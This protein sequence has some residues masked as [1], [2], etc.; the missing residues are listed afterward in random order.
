MLTYNLNETRLPLYD[1]LYRAIKADIL[2]GRLAPGEKLPSKRTLAQHLRLSV[3]TVQNA[4]AQLL[5]EGYLYSEE[6][7]GYY[8][9]TIGDSLPVP[10]QKAPAATALSEPEKAP[11]WF[12]DLVSNGISAEDFP[13]TV[14]SRT[15]RRV[16]LEKEKQLL[17]PL[18]FNGTPELR[19]AIA[20]HLARFR[21]LSVDPDQI[22]VGAGTEYLYTL[23]IQLLGRDCL[24]AVEDP[25]YAKIRRVYAASGVS[26]CTVPLDEQGLSAQ[27]LEESGAQCV[28]ISPSHHYP[29][30]IVMPIGRRRELLRWAAQSPQRYIIDDDYDSEFR[31]SGRP[32]PTMMSIDENDRVIYMNTFS[33]TIAPSIRISYMVLP[34]PLMERFKRAFSFYACT[35]SGFEQYTLAAFMA[36]GHFERHLNRMKNRYRAKRDAIL[37]AIRESTLGDVSTVFEPNAGLHFLLHFHTDADDETIKRSAAEQGIRISAL[38]DY[39]ADPTHTDFGLPCRHTFLINYSGVETDKFPEVLRRLAACVPV[40]QQQR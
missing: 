23:V 39:L 25:G 28:H 4:Y 38:S 20:D 8:V 7:R 37:S 34:V 9:S 35:V 33:K 10:A 32:L 30:G 5:A 13:F 36:D 17:L 26:F 6:K 1:A 21:G 16:I 18:D 12:A 31:F 3:A 24:Y 2:S 29:T 22:I 14:W 15:M 27:A 11:A 40:N 19:R